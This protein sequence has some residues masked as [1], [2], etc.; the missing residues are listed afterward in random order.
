VF[1]ICYKRYTSVTGSEVQDR[2]QLLEILLHSYVLSGTAYKG[3][4][5]TATIIGVIRSLLPENH[6]DI[7]P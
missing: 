4:S 1:M 6:L 3:C 2:L 5:F 7:D